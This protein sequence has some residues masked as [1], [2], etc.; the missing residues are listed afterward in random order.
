MR[1]AG[2]LHL[3]EYEPTDKVTAATTAKAIKIAEW[4]ES[5]AERAFGAFAAENENK[6]A[7]YIVKRLRE[8]GNQEISKREIARMLNKT[9]DVIEPIL[10]LLEIYGYVKEKE[11]SKPKQKNS[12]V[13]YQINPYIFEN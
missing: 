3:C 8:K 12:K 7:K 4:A 13:I 1:I 11:L 9:N 10:E 5:Q 2:L 6:T